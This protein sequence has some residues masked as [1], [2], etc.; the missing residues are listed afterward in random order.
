MVT[1]DLPY[2]IQTSAG[3]RKYLCSGIYMPSVTTVLSATESEKS[4]AG[5]RNWQKNNPGALEAASTR[6]SAI[7]LGC[8]NYL[9]GLEPGVPEDYLDNAYS[10][11]LSRADERTQIRFAHI[12]ID[13]A[14]HDSPSDAFK[15][16]QEVQQ[17]L[18]SGEDF[19]DLA[20]VYSD[21][22][23]SKDI[24]GDLEYFASDIFP[25]EFADEVLKI[26]LT[27]ELKKTEWVEVDISKKE[28][29]SQASIQ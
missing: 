28:D 24:G 17:K 10:E 15:V 21:D 16:I 20:S 27:K 9:R 12:M 22:I 2:R 26:A 8:E 23:V 7:H 3:H 25:V 5:L 13:K 19:S 6:G 18:S 14:N 4:K 11:Y 1:S 29:K